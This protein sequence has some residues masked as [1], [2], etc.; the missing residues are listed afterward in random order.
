[1]VKWEYTRTSQASLYLLTTDSFDIVAGDSGLLSTLQVYSR[2]AP[3]QLLYSLSHW[4][5][6][7]VV[8]AIHMSEYC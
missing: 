5:H 3:G 2:G 4:R 8:A 6:C 1:V 7:H